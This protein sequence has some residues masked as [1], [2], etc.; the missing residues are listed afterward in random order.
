MAVI[1]VVD[2]DKDIR[3]SVKTI[4]EAE[5]YD[6]VIAENGRE[7]LDLFRDPTFRPAVML[8]DLMMPVMNGWQVL[9]HIAR[10]RRLQK[11][12]IILMS[13]FFGER[14]VGDP[15]TMLIKPFALDRMLDLVEHHCRTPVDEPS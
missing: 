14:F 12:P 9:D 4:L 2:D 6:V 13:A 11:I 3:S 5:A 8:L 7:A 15:Y 1:L 10:D